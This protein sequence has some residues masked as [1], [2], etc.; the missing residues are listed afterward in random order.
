MTNLHSCVCCHG[1]PPFI[2]L[3]TGCNVSLPENCF[4]FLG[5]MYHNDNFP[6]FIF[7]SDINGKWFEASF[8]L[9]SSRFLMCLWLHQEKMGWTTGEFLKLFPFCQ[10]PFKVHANLTFLLLLLWREAWTWCTKLAS[11]TTFPGL[12][13]LFKLSRIDTCFNGE[14]GQKLSSVS[15]IILWVKYTVLTKTNFDGDTRT[16]FCYNT[17]APA[18]KYLG[19]NK[20]QEHLSWLCLN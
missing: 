10:C 2:G 19:K 16:F 6:T 15:R 5:L 8:L 13:F 1:D 14:E 7:H 4:F 18:R 17:P 9:I 20:L 12:F 3:V 11:R